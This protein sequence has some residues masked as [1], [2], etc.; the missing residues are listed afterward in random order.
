M[1]CTSRAGTCEFVAPQIRL[2]RPAE[3][4]RMFFEVQDPKSGLIG[5]LGSG[6]ALAGATRQ[7]ISARR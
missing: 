6:G 5:S 3:R 1:V 7:A 2:I 4:R